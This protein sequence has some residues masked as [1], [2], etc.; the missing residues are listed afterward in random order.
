MK[1]EINIDDYD[2]IDIISIEDWKEEH[3]YDIE[4][5]EVNC[6]YARERKSNIESISHN[7]ATICMFSPEDEKMINAKTGNWFLENPQRARSNNSVI[8][9]KNTVTEET[10]HKF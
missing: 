9:N 3:T 10:F 7:S 5:N 1:M 8:L 4:V 2:I 6:F